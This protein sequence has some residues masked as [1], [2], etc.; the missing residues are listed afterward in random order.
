MYLD[1]F[2]Y[3][4]LFIPSYYARGIT[5]LWFTY[6]VVSLVGVNHN[7]LCFHYTFRSGDHCDLR[8]APGPWFQ[9]GMLATAA[10]H[11]MGHP[12]M[13]IFAQLSMS[14]TAVLSYL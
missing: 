7:I 11:D 4:Y 13:L 5:L 12:M 3:F 6:V 14:C 2:L 10:V 8:S 9:V 1:I